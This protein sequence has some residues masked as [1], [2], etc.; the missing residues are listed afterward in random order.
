M[1]NNVNVLNLEGAQIGFRNF[2]GN[3]GPYNKAGDR[4]FVVFLDPDKAEELKD[5]GWNV[6]W[7][8]ERQDIA[9]EDDDRN[10]YLP[11]Q[12]AFNRFPP[13][14]ILITDGNA[15]RIEESEIETLDF[16]EIEKSDIVLNPYH[17]SV[18]GKEGIKAYLKAIYVTV[19]TDAFSSK[20]GV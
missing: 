8:K 13:K 19:A 4:N 10:P 1:A 12:V 17:W 18:N 6:K 20:Y 9:P 5:Q 16:V 14:V 11:V 7:P 3:E 2:A 15:T